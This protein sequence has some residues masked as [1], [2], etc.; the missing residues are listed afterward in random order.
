MVSALNQAD[1]LAAEVRGEAVAIS[2]EKSATPANR[3]C[4][5]NF[6]Q[7][8][9]EIRPRKSGTTD[10]M[11]AVQLLVDSAAVEGWEFLIF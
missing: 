7:W 8:T 2:K 9:F 6:S 11:A 4:L 1:T 10:A 3:D 5:C